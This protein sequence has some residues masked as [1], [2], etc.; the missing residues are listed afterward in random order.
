MKILKNKKRYEDST[1]CLVINVELDEYSE[2]LELIKHLKEVCPPMIVKA[3]LKKRK[4]KVLL[5]FSGFYN[6]NYSTLYN[7]SSNMMLYSL[8]KL[9]ELFPDL[10]KKKIVKIVKEDYEKL[11]TYISENTHR[12]DFVNSGIKPYPFPFHYEHHLGDNSIAFFYYSALHYSAEVF[13][14]VN[15]KCNYIDYKYVVKTNQQ[16]LKGF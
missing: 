9:G 5:D 2:V 6:N 16:F 7:I 8:I 10:K 11:L 12:D 14:E 4:I 15:E 1:R 3:K 13:N